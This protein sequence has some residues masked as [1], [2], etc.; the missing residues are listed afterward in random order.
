MTNESF[1]NVLEESKGY[2]GG[3][4]KK[5]KTQINWT[6]ELLE[7]FIKCQKDPVY[8]GEKYM[9]IRTTDPDETGS[10]IRIIDLYDYQKDI[11]RAMQ[12]DSSI[13]AECARQSGKTTAVTVYVLWYIIF[14][15]AVE[16]AILANKGSTAREILSR[17]KMA[18][19]DLPDWLQQGVE[20]WNKEYIALE[21]KSKIVAA[22]TSADNIRG[23][24]QNLVF[25][26]EAAWVD[27]WDEFFTS[28]Y[29]TL[30]SGKTT[31]LMLVSTVNGMNHFHQIT[32]LARQKKNN[33]TLISVGWQD[34]PGRDEEWKQKTLAAMNF[35]YEKFAQEYENRYLGSSGTLI[36]GSKLQE[37]VSSIPISAEDKLKIYQYPEEGRTYSLIADVSQGKGL[38]HSAVSVVDITEMPYQQV[39]TFYDNECS[40]MDFAEKMNTLGRRYNNAYVLIEINDI[41]STVAHIL[42][43]TFEYPNMLVS[44]DM[45]RAGKVISQSGSSR[46]DLGLKTT[47]KT[48]RKGCALLKL[49]IEQ[50][51]LLIQDQNTLHELSTF[52]RKGKSYEAE[53]GKN[54]DL[55][56]TL[57]LFAYFSEQEFFKQI[58]EISTFEE[59]RDETSDEIETSMAILGI[60]VIPERQVVD[61][62]EL[63]K[64]TDEFWQL[65]DD[66]YHS[67]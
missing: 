14:H 47:A 21:N 50:D 18:Y 23:R 26:D 3:L 41:G 11:I 12:H 20:D 29:P 55:V 56:M 37:M 39:A 1:G 52:I 43:D 62:L 58:T 46:N 65:V 9:K 57:V 10:R 6:P 34:V 5:A 54:D 40:P 44:A 17:I 49:L 22:A 31:K 8:F 35:D 7:E 53:K 4:V 15:E 42:H 48:K 32:T 24:A 63:E 61:G 45:G 28:V 30:S 59:I 38:D 27:N 33:Y 60:Q 64:H 36:K 13:V 16:V 51:Q 19:E 67:F 66:D 2:R 25:I